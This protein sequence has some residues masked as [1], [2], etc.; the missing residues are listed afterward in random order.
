[1]AERPIG[2]RV[3]RHRA[4]GRS[5]ARSASISAHDSPPPASIAASESLT[6]RSARRPRPI[7]TVTPPRACIVGCC[8][9]G[10]A[11]RPHRPGSFPNPTRVRCA[12]CGRKMQGSWNRTRRSPFIPQLR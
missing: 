9:R 12:Q 6:E 2:G 4:D 8:S 3:R 7:R 5:W 10:C 1:M 11:R